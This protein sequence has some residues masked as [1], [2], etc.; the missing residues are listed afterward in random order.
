MDA[1]KK[2][3]ILFMIIVNAAILIAL[4]VFVIPL[5]PKDK[6]FSSL[7]QVSMY[8]EERDNVVI[9]RTIDIENFKF[10]AVASVDGSYFNS[11]LIYYKNSK[12]YLFRATGFN[13]VFMKSEY[14][15]GLIVINKISSHFVVLV[16]T[17]EFDFNGKPLLVSDNDGSDFSQLKIT[18]RSINFYRV[19]DKLPK[20]YVII[21]NDRSFSVN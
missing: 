13:T 17:N 16:H 19:Y 3:W 12:Y 8:L 21:I 5:F 15:Y 10:T 14:A 4:I 7:D 2:V 6:S 1:R 18:D 9:T 11:E 20:N